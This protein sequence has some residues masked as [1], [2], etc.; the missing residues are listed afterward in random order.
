MKTET[1][2]TNPA[3]EQSLELAIAIAVILDTCP[4]VAGMVKNFAAHD[5]L[6]ERLRLFGYTR[7]PMK[8]ANAE[9][10]DFGGFNFAKSC[11]FCGNYAEFSELTTTTE[12]KVRTYGPRGWGIVGSGSSPRFDQELK[13]QFEARLLDRCVSQYERLDYLLKVVARIAESKSLSYTR[14]TAKA[15]LVKDGKTERPPV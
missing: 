7:D 9:R 3:F 15:A 12:K 5:I 11:G 1:V 4:D 8:H 2:D 10:A 13:S 6:V 14:K